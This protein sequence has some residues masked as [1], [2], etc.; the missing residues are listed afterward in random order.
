MLE[1]GKTHN[2]ITYRLTINTWS[3]LR[4]V[5]YWPLED[6]W[7]DGCWKRRRRCRDAER[8][9]SMDSRG[10]E[11]GAS[12]DHSASPQIITNPPPYIVRRHGSPVFTG[13]RLLYRMLLVMLAA[14]LCLALSD[15]HSRGDDSD[16]GP[17]SPNAAR[18]LASTQ[19]QRANGRQGG[20]A[21]LTDRGISPASCTPVNQSQ[22]SG[23]LFCFG[24]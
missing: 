22:S 21:P 13:I 14:V 2:L 4:A 24:S 15:I 5:L 1:W 3:Y 17:P 8:R 20:A 10:V 18:S 23:S 12:L 19:P 9:P 6:G 7:D 16:S 11:R